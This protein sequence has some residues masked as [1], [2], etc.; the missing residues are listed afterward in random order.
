MVAKQRETPGRWMDRVF[1]TRPL[2]ETLLR[3]NDRTA[4]DRRAI[5]RHTVVAVI[6]YRA[7]QVSF[8][9]SEALDRLI[10][11]WLLR[12]R[13]PPVGMTRFIEVGELSWYRVNDWDV[14]QR[15]RRV[16]GRVPRNLDC[17][18]LY[19]GW[20]HE[21]TRGNPLPV[22]VL[23]DASWRILEVAYGE[24]HEGEILGLSPGIGPDLPP[25]VDRTRP[26]LRALG[27]KLGLR[28]FDDQLHW[29][30]GT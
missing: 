16:F 21:A 29:F 27:D 11:R 12:G 6:R 5:I 15:V 2:F 28:D 1:F 8:T 10:F 3:E 24:E 9:V 23:M 22:F 17:T 25:S 18:V 13:V 26:A 4:A 20:R 19:C 14:A 7:D 30:T